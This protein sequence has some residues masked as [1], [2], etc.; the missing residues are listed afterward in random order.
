MTFKKRRYIDK[1]LHLEPQP[2]VGYDKLFNLMLRAF[3]YGWMFAILDECE[4]EFEHRDIHTLNIEEQ[5]RLYR[6]ARD[7]VARLCHRNELV[8]V[9]PITEPRQ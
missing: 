3:D 4:N 9:P 2:Q 7:E 1:L 6:L 8:S 5:R